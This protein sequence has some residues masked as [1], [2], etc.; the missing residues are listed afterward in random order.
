MINI[1][2][3][4]DDI[5][6]LQNTKKLCE[7]YTLE[8]KEHEF[9]IESYTLATDLLK[10]LTEGQY[11]NYILL[12]DIY[13]PEM[14]G[15]E[16]A[17]SIRE[18]DNHCQIVF[19]TT[20]MAHAV[21]AFSLHAAHYLVKPYTFAQLEDALNKAISVIEKAQNANILLK[22][23]AGLQKINM[24]D[25]IYSE[26]DK[27]NQILHL[28]TGK[29]LSF[30]ISCSELYELLSTDKRFYKCGSTY[31]MNLEQITEVTTRH[32]LFENRDEL[33]MQRRQYKE[34]LELY[35]RYLLENN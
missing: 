2:I 26:T 25:I 14:T 33:P 29:C 19:L 21:E 27:H 15:I 28:K 7:S 34:L 32:I 30:R 31:I 17:R 13:M 3:C 24:A 11:S 9:R 5:R 23:A 16:L 1:V 35:T 20:S 4:D 10:R 22:T 12:L 8:H 18:R 6:E